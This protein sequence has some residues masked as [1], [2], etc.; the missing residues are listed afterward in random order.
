MHKHLLYIVALI[1]VLLN[2]CNNNSSIQLQQDAHDSSDHGIDDVL[3]ATNKT[4]LSKAETIHPE[5]KDITDTLHVS[6]YAGYDERRNKVVPVRSSGRIEKLYVKLN[7]Q[8]IHKGDK[9]LDLYS[10]E[11]NA[12]IN[13]YRHHLQT[14]SDSGLIEGTREKIKLLGITQQQIHAIEKGKTFSN[15]ITIYSPYEGFIIYDADEQQSKAAVNSSLAAPGMDGMNGGNDQQGMKMAEGSTG[16]R[17]REGDYVSKGQSLFKINDCRVV[18]GLFSIPANAVS[19]LKKHAAVI[20][21]SPG[22]SS[23]VIHANIDFIEP[24]YQGGRKFIQ[25]RVYIKNPD[26]RLKINS[27]LQ[28]IITYSNRH[29]SVPSSSV[30]NLGKRNFVWVVKSRNEN[31]VKALEAKE[32]AAGAGSGGFI[33][34]LSGITAH[35]EIARDAGYLLD[36]ESLINKEK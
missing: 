16:M 1:A 6:G 33:E 10:P 2:G 9:I 15:T 18:Y 29:L 12:F 31:G 13:E 25:A 34:V 11:L 26:L 20:I 30:L 35:D 17:I 19:E 3:E 4:I 23:E 21:Q 28:G 5:L 24:A 32:I 7:Y 14:P 36:S 22:N 8:F 27:L